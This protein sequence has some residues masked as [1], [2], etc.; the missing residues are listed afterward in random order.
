MNNH[1]KLSDF[2]TGSGFRNGQDALEAANREAD[3]RLGVHL[4]QQFGH[5][6]QQPFQKV[7][8]AR[9]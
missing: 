1:M 2:I 4:M 7:R 3:R 6:L 9:G 5:N 8:V